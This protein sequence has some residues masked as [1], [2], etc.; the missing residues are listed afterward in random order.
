VQAEIDAAR[1]AATAKAITLESHIEPGVRSVL[2][3]PSRVEQIVWKV[4]SNAI[5]FTPRD[6][7]I[8]ITL[9]QVGSAAEISVQDSGVGIDGSLLPHVFDRF[10]QGDSTSHRA[11][12]GLG[13]GLAIVRQLMELHGGTARAESAGNNCGS[14]FTLTFPIPALTTGDDHLTRAPGSQ[15]LRGLR[16]LVVED[17]P[18]SRELMICL[19]RDKGA[20]V[21]AVSSV[22]EA[23][24]EYAA[25]ST[26]GLPHKRQSGPEVSHTTG[27][28][29]RTSGGRT[30]EERT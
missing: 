19:L 27:V 29:R 14:T 24:A 2:A 18:D 20:S 28:T 30:D 12:G 5:K 21:T 15:L 9:R 23:V 8:Q 10:R 25:D 3:D 16:V 11:F 22:R 13:L 17:E 1:P 26:F 7:R 4:L 6:G